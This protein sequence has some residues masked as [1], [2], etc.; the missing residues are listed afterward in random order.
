MTILGVKVWIQVEPY[1]N[2]YIKGKGEREIKLI[3]ILGTEDIEGIAE[4]LFVDICKSLCYGYFWF[5]QTI[6]MIYYRQ[7]VFT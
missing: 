1:P 7:R 3:G 4:T 2:L 5:C 6:N